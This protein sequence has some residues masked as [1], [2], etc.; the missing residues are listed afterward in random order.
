MDITEALKQQASKWTHAQAL[1]AVKTTEYAEHYT[2][3]YDKSCE[4]EQHIELVSILVDLGFKPPAKKAHASAVKA[5]AL[6]KRLIKELESLGYE[7]DEAVAMLDESGTRAIADFIKHELETANAFSKEPTAKTTA[8]K[9]EEKD[10]ALVIEV[11]SK[12]KTKSIEHKDFGSGVGV[13]TARPL[14]S[15]V[16]QEPTKVEPTTPA[17][18]E[19][20]YDYNKLPVALQRLV[21][22]IGLHKLPTTEAMPVIAVVG[23]N[24]DTRRF[25]YKCTQGLASLHAYGWLYL[26]NAKE[27]QSIGCIV[28]APTD[29]ELL[30]KYNNSLLD[31][32]KVLP[33]QADYKLMYPGDLREC[34]T[35]DYETTAIVVAPPASTPEKSAKVK[36]AAAKPE[37]EPIPTPDKKTPAITEATLSELATATNHMKK[38]SLVNQVLVA[39]GEEKVSSKCKKDELAPVVS[40]LLAQFNVPVAEPAPTT[41]V[42][43]SKATKEPQAPAPTKAE[44]EKW[45]VSTGKGTKKGFAALDYNW[46]SSIDRATAAERLGYVA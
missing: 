25:I 17:S 41:K 29:V 7:Y 42:T 28:V 2:N 18:A 19:R 23:Y 30:K 32:S 22:D 5:P 1:D 31:A 24:Q 20:M 11:D 4:R 44:L 34:M 26:T 45:Y 33:A 40:R 39:L 35:F 16:K 46:R 9:S 8:I 36:K 14:P 10:V 43:K 21:D 15:V 27:W 3:G 37:Q 38:V 6:T 12:G 13:E